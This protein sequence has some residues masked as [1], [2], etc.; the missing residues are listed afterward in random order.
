MCRGSKGAC[1]TRNKLSNGMANIAAFKTNKRS[2][3]YSPTFHRQIRA[4][5][6]FGCGTSIPQRNAP[7]Q[8]KST[9]Q[10]K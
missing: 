4:E 6:A 7:K 9:G 2:A 8:S 1:Y 5:T 10:S 3:A